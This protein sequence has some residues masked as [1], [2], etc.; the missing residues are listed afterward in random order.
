TV[1]QAPKEQ[2]VSSGPFGITS[3]IVDSDQPGT[4]EMGLLAGVYT[5]EPTLIPPN[6]PMGWTFGTGAGPVASF[7][8]ADAEAEV[9]PGSYARMDAPLAVVF[10]GGLAQPVEMVDYPGFM[11]GAEVGFGLVWYA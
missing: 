5:T 9:L 8:S 7:L 10:D 4:H 2:V 3:L 1:E 6:V 11:C